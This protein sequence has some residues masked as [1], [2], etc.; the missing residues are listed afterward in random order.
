M[1]TTKPKP[2]VSEPET[3]LD[4]LAVE[5]SYGSRWVNLNDGE[6]YKISADQTRETTTKSWRKVT[7]DSPVLGGNYLIHAVPEMV[8]ETIGVWVHGRTQSEVAD[9][10]FGLTRLF[11]QYDYRI[12]WTTDDYREYWR[13]Q[14][15]ESAMSRG[16]V[17][18]HSMMAAAHFS[19]PRYPDVTRERI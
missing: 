1:S 9:N 7:A 3:G 16:Q 5:I 19:V 15:A 4:Y 2:F 6:V 18:T 8:T 11:E 10:L 12:R 13:C 17:W 14:L